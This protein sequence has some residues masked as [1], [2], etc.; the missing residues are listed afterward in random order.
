MIFRLYDIVYENCLFRQFKVNE[1]LFVEYKSLN[2]EQKLKVLS[3]DNF[4]IYILGGKKVWQ[5]FHST[6][7]ATA[8]QAVFVK[9]GAN[10]VHQFYDEG[11]LH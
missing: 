11:F 8:G 2:D 10:I 5:T 9:K 4:F 7:E 1:L 6:Y 3:Q